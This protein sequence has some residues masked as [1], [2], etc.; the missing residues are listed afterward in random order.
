MSNPLYTA[1]VTATGGRNGHVK[2]SDGKI[3]LAVNKPEAMGGNGQGTNP[4]QL[5]ASAWSACFLGAMH[6]VS[7]KDNVDLKDAQVKVKVSFHAENN[8]FFLSAEIQSHVPS[9]SQDQTQQLIEKAHR[10]CPYSKAIKGNV[11]VSLKAI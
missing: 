6:A 5:F 4:E 3:D 8:A 11:E 2:S 10:V 9:L 7:E 1:E